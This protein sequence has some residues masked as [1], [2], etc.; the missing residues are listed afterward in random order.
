MSNTNTAENS[1]LEEELKS[2][3]VETLSLDSI[4]PEE[5]VS[6]A[7]LF[8]NVTEKSD[9]GSLGLDSI[10]ALELGIA[11]QKRYGVKLDSND[12]EIRAHFHS[13]KTLANFVASQR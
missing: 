2:L 9:H 6:S 5:I 4:K 3:I 13:V 7:A 1:I 11:I 12:P 8:G 10:D